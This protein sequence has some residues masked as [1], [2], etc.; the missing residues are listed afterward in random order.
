MTILHP[1]RFNEAAPAGFDG[2][3]DWDFLKGAFPRGITPMDIDGKVEV[4]GNFLL[5]ETKDVGVPVK[6][7]Q[8]DSLARL[9]RLGPITL[10]V[11]RG[12]LIPVAWRWINRKSHSPIFHADNCCADIFQ[13]CSK[14]AKWADQNPCPRDPL[15]HLIVEDMIAP[16]LVPDSNGSLR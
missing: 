12:K 6:D 11:I 1:E 4:G 16:S 9:L 14:W 3:W 10:I 2:V 8:A 15:F 13:F 5:F 7:G